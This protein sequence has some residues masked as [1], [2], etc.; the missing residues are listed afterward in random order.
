MSTSTRIYPRRAVPIFV[1]LKQEADSAPAYVDLCVDSDDYR[2][3]AGKRRV[4]E[5][6]VLAAVTES[7]AIAPNGVK[8]EEEK[9]EAILREENGTDHRMG[10]YATPPRVFFVDAYPRSTGRGRSEHPHST[11]LEAGAIL[12]C[13]LGC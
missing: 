10:R 12:C 13:S 2:P 9:L 8:E 6:M 7:A 5:A 1:D 11:P 3:I 4:T